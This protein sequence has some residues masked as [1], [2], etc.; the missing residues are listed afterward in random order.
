MY[1]KTCSIC[2]KEFKTRYY[3]KNVCSFPCKQKRTRQSG[4][5]TMKHKRTKH[6]VNCPPCIICGFNL[7]TDIHHEG[8]AT[9][10]LCPNH[11][12]LITRNIKTLK[13]LLEK[14]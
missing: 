2:D 3:N 13:E 5:I 7:T 14:C 1:I 6:L 11:H 10:V 12:A 9:Y 4:I 8:K